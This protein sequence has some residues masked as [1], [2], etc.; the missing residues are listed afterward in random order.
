[1]QNCAIVYTGNAHINAGVDVAEIA[2]YG[3]HEQPYLSS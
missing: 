2:G 1:M 3:V